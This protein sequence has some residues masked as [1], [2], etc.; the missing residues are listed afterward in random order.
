MLVCS[1]CTSVFC[2]FI[3]RCYSVYCVC[4]IVA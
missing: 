1:M 4:G 2:G 3:A